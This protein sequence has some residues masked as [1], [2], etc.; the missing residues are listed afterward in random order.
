MTNTMMDLREVV[1]SAKLK[2]FVYPDKPKRLLFVILSL[3][4]GTAY[5]LIYL[6]AIYG[7]ESLYVASLFVF[8]ALSFPSFLLWSGYGIKPTEITA[9]AYIWAVFLQAFWL[10]FISCF[11]IELFKRGK[12]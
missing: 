4:L 7:F 3:L 11:F 8:I 12:K 10:Y 5:A 1:R 9:F 2:Q 6:S